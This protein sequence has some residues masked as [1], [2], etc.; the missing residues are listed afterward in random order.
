MFPGKTAPAA[1]VAVVHPLGDDMVL[2]GEAWF[3]GE[4]FEGSDADTRLLGGVNWNLGV[5]GALRFALA[6]GL[7]D[8]APDLQLLAGYAVHF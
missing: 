7:S 8:G 2:V 3:E 6:G 1:G 5:V 4:R